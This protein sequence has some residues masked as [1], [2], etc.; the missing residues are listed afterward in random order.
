[1]KITRVTPFLVEEVPTS[2]GWSEGIRVLL[3]KVEDE[4]GLAGWGEAFALSPRQTAIRD[5]MMILADGLMKLP[6]ASP[7]RFLQDVAAVEDAGHQSIDFD[8]AVS[9]LEIALWDLAGK[10]LGVPVHTLL[11]G[12]IRSEVPI[13]ANAW[14]SPTQPPEAIAARC[15]KMRSEGYGAVKIYPLRQP[16][17]ELTEKLVRLTREAIGPDA[18]MMLDFAVE[19]DPRRALQAARLCAPYN[20]FWIEEPVSGEDLAAMA[21][22]RK[23]VDMRVTTGERQSGLTHY[24]DILTLRAADVLNPDI[25]GVGGILRMV[26]IATMAQAHSVLFSPHNWNSTNVG[27]AAMMQVSAV[28]PNLCYAELY[29]DYLEL[30]ARYAT[31]DF[32]IAN[33]VATVPTTP[34]I[35]VTIDEAALRALCVKED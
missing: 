28:L 19:Q 13:Y 2:D 5:I 26:E 32:V 1:M 14:D 3:V 25:C 9:A 24:R 27:F 33:G 12:A 35:G 18:D 21:D 23:R 4:T 31:T 15:A 22:F 8:S 10:R 11:G 17:L 34:G 6:E 29:Y 7:R 16:T 20:P 30:G